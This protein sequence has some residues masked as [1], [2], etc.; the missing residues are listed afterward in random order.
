MR[1]D[2]DTLIRIAGDITERDLGDEIIVIKNSGSEFHTF[3]DTALDIWKKAHEGLS[4][5]ELLAFVMKEYSVAEDQAW[6]DLVAFLHD[7]DDKKLIRD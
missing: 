7:L 3:R 1:L 4:A 5:G 6:Q 2:R